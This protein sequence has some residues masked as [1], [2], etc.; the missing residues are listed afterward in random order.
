[1]GC[2]MGCMVCFGVVFGG[3]MFGNFGVMG[4]LG[5]IGDGGVGDV[6]FGI[7]FGMIGVGLG[8]GMVLIWGF[9]VGV[10]VG[11]VL[12]MFGVMG[13]CIVVLGD[14]MFFGVKSVLNF[15]KE[16]MLMLVILNGLGV[17]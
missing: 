4:V 12:V 13:V 1:M 11:V 7:G 15:L 8:I 9:C 16:I 5:M 10:R 17:E 2:V 6:I 14:G 3:L